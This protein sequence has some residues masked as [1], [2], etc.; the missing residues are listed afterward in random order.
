MI[1][2]VSQPFILVLVIPLGLVAK[3]DNGA[4]TGLGAGFLDLVDEPEALGRIGPLV[5]IGIAD[6]LQQV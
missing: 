6:S 3:Q 2:H 1:V 5:R 4:T